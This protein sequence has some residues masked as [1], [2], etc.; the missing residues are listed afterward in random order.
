MNVTEVNDPP[1]VTVNQGSVTA[2]EGGDKVLI[3]SFVSVSAG[4]PSENLQTV[5]GSCVANIP[6]LVEGTIVLGLSGFSLQNPIGSLEFTPAKDLSGTTTVKCTVSDDGIPVMTSEFEFELIISETNDPP[7]AT[8][9]RT[10]VTLDEDVALFEV[11][12]MFTG[13]SPG[14]QAEIDKGET[15]TINC[16]AGDNSL[17]T[18]AGRPKVNSAGTLSMIPAPDMVGTT[19]VD[20]TIADSGSPSMSIMKSFTVTVAEKN[21]AP[22]AVVTQERVTVAEDSDVS[23]FPGFV[24]PLSPGPASESTQTIK[25]TCFPT[26]A[27]LFS[28]SV[29]IASFGT[30]IGELSFKP[31]QDAV[32]VTEVKCDV[33]DSN[34]GTE[35]PLTTSFSFTVEITEV[36]DPP[37][38]LLKLMEISVQEDIGTFVSKAFLYQVAPG[39]T[40]EDSQVVTTTCV[41]EH[42]ALFSSPPLIASTGDLTFVPAKDVSGKT[43]VTCTMT[44]N[45]SPAASTPLVF[46]VTI[47]DTN[48]PPT[49]TLSRSMVSAAEDAGNVEFA[50]FITGMS[51]GPALENGQTFTT[52]CLAE[53]PEMFK[54]QPTIAQQSPTVGKLLF[55]P[56]DNAVGSTSVTCTIA[57]DVTPPGETKLTFSVT[58]TE[59]ND[60]PVVTY[61][62]ENNV[63][64]TQDIVKRTYTYPSFLQA[65]PGPESEGTQGLDSEC[66]ATNPELFEVQPTV[67]V[68]NGGQGNLSFVAKA[69]LSEANAITS[70]VT[71]TFSDNG[72]PPL[73]TSTTF[74]IDFELVCFLF[75]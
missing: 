53:K 40:S 66:L 23:S 55:T 48:D 45:G 42:T 67:N 5:R 14:P 10:E 20:C 24:N 25:T 38:G 15:Y 31:A 33:V 68:I 4:P 1:V 62:G 54:N 60:E 26:N 57:D 32:G 13:L 7:T 69:G 56:A 29:S 58:L 72:M 27:A 63:K 2:P 59:T 64:V 30:K 34:T 44:D 70:K 61:P 47:L 49:G 35:A 43:D 19:K 75:C 52:T 37:T 28:T 51:G 22:L 71:C 12:N 18:L 41:A 16:L 50:D 74:D 46:S 17:F 39:P 21:D 11:L 36:N 8:L 65:L 3:P 9:T 6:E 73:T